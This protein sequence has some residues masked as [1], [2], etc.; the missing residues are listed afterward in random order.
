MSKITITAEWRQDPED[1]AKDAIFLM[2][3]GTCLGYVD[4][5]GGN[6]MGCVGA[7]MGA[8]WVY[9]GPNLEAAKRAVEAEYDSPE[10]A[11]SGGGK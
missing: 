5:H 6:Y 3:G 10:P 1:V 9:H 4:P 2:A 11:I 7:G 8:P